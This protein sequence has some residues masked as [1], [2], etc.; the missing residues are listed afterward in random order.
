MYNVFLRLIY[1][2][3]KTKHGLTN[4]SYKNKSSSKIWPNSK[5]SKDTLNM[6]TTFLCYICYICHSQSKNLSFFLLVPLWLL[7]FELQHKSHQEDFLQTLW[8]TLT[9]LQLYSEHYTYHEQSRP[10]KCLS[11]NC[12]C[13]NPDLMDERKVV[14]HFEVF[15]GLSC[16]HIFLLLTLPCEQLLDTFLWVGQDP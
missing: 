5:D 2:Y 15:G 7:S 1:I 11:A 10:S 9:L 16:Q 6:S 3:K 12:Y 14:M 4:S 13:V 8:A